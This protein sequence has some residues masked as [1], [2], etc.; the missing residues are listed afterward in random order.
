MKLDIVLRK[1]DPDIISST[2]TWFVSN[3]S[4][5]ESF[6]NSSYQLQG[7]TDRQIG[8]HCGVLIAHKSNLVLEEVKTIDIT[9]NFFSYVH[10]FRDILVTLITLYNPPMNS[11]CRTECR[12]TL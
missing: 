8:T 3:V 9:E 11:S 7:R 6:L 12:K 1:G 4:D 2:E 5:C 10:V